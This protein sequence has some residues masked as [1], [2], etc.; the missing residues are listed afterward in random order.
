M[1]YNKENLAVSIACSKEETRPALNGV[2]FESDGSTVATDGHIL[3]HVEACK[4]E[5]EKFPKTESEDQKIDEKGIIVPLQNVQAIAK[6][7]LKRTILPILKHCQYVNNQNGNGENSATFVTTDLENT[8]KHKTRLIEGKYP[9]WKQLFD[10]PEP[11]YEI[12]VSAYVLEKL[13]KF[14]KATEEREPKLI[15]LKF[16]GRNAAIEFDAGET[17]SGQKITGLFMPCKTKE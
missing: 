5:V 8:Q 11:E 10:L 17:E 4:A 9:N 15:K 7:I 3:C 6:T 14:V 12:A 13:A 16:H 1:L 2:H